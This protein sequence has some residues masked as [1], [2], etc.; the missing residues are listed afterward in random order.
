[1]C[2]CLVSV[3]KRENQTL[4]SKR[5]SL[6]GFEPRQ[7]AKRVFECGAAAA[8]DV[9]SLPAQLFLPRPSRRTSS[10]GTVERGKDKANAAKAGANRKQT[11]SRRRCRSNRAAPTPRP[12][13]HCG[14]TRQ[15]PP[16]RPVDRAGDAWRAAFG[17][18]P[19]IAREQHTQNARTKPRPR[20]FTPYA[21]SFPPTL[22]RTP[23]TRA[24]GLPVLSPGATSIEALHSW[25]AL[26]AESASSTLRSPFLCGG[27]G[28]RW[29]GGPPPNRPLSAHTLL[30]PPPPGGPQPATWSLAEAFARGSCFLGFFRCK[31]KKNQKHKHAGVGPGKMGGPPLAR[32]WERAARGRGHWPCQ[33]G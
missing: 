2:F 25:H 15:P 10:V 30:R 13:S 12:P 23:A 11:R 18:T 9:A 21:F 31:S 3:F 22:R 7:R 6:R 20:R 33:D 19:H 4:C 14:R 8:R 28:S 32:A 1:M 27:D 29:G 16:T 24:G 26:S 17:C 5:G